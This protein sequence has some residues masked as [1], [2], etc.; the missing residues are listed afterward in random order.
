MKLFLLIILSWIFLSACSDGDKILFPAKSI[1]RMDLSNSTALFIA[2]K[3]AGYSKGR[4]SGTEIDKIY[5][6]TDDGLIIEVKMIDADGD[7]VTT[8]QQPQYI[9]NIDE[10]FIIVEF[11]DEAYLVRKED[12][13]VFQL[14]DIPRI[15]NQLSYTADQVDTDDGANVYYVSWSGKLIKI[16]IS[17]PFQLVSSIQSATGDRINLYALDHKGNAAYAG[18][19]SGEHEILRYKKNTGGFE[20]LPG[21]TNGSHTTFWTDFS[22]DIY[23]YNASLTS[24]IY[25]RSVLKITDPFELTEYGTENLDIG[26]GFKTMLKIKDKQK[27]IASGGCTYIYQLYSDDGITRNIP[28]VTFNLESVKLGGASDNYY[29]LSGTSTES[30]AVLVKIDPDTDDFTYIIN[31][32]YDIY[33]M[34]VSANDEILFNALRL[35]DGKIVLGRID[36]QG[37]INILDES[38]EEEIKILARV[39]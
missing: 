17:D 33:K 16:D 21:E 29:Y 30:K 11:A 37:Q 13:A 35:A 26:C 3:N 10:K 19:D 2:G 23:Y 25:T 9:V 7:V 32:E 8:Y 5:K 6:I 15:P 24:S 31:G 22:G 28:Y 20:I 14:N 39:N 18:F 4:A 27:I 38:L 34:T 36:D 1:T 12:G